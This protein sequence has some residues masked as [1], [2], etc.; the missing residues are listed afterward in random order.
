MGLDVGQQ[1]PFR[2]LPL[3]VVA[4]HAGGLVRQEDVLV[5]IDDAEPGR[6]HLAVGVIV[7]GLLEKFV[8]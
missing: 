8:A 6:R 5:L 7:A 3:R 2:R 4:E 1:C